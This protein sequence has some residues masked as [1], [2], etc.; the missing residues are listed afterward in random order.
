[1]VGRERELDALAE[2]FASTCE[3]TPC[4][5][6]IGGEAGVGKSR[7]VAEF[8]AGLPGRA[9]VLPGNC[10]ALGA[11]GLDFAP[12][13]AILR[14][15]VRELGAVDVLNLLPR[16]EAGDLGRL[17]PALGPPPAPGDTALARARLF[18]QVLTLL[19]GLA[20]QQP[21]VL[22]VEDAHW[23][24]RSSRDL[25]GF[26]ARSCEAAL[27]T[28]VTYRTDE[29]GPADPLRP[30]LAD[31]ARLKRGR[32]LELGRLARS[33]T[34]RQLRG[35]LGHEPAP[36]D[37][38]RIYR[39][40]GGNPLLVE[41]LLADDEPVPGPIRDLLVAPLEQLP[42]P[43]REVVRAAAVGGSQIRHALLAAVTGLDDAA[44]SRALRPAVAAHLLVAG[45][46]GYVF[47]HALIQEM[48][49]TDL[50]PGERAA[51]HLRYA[52]ALESGPPAALPGRASVE[53]AHH[54]HAAGPAHAVHALTT[55]WQ[56]AGDAR[57]ALAYAEELYM[58]TL[59]LDRWGQVPDAAGFLGTGRPAVMAAAIEAAV[60][61]GETERAMT[62]IETALAEP[63]PDPA[64]GLLLRHRGELRHA[65]GLPGDIDDL[66]EAA[67]LVPAGHAARASVL[68]A[69]AN[70]LLTIPREAA[71][72]AAAEEAMRAASAVGDIRSQVMA[73]VNLGYARARAGD[74]NAQLPGFAAARASA[75]RAGDAATVLHAYRC[76]AD[77]LQGIGSYQ[78]AAE[79]SRRGLAAAARAGLAR[80]AGPTQ[81]G[82][83]AEALICLGHWD[84]ADEILDHAL[85]LTPTPSLRGY[86]LV[87][88][89]SIDLA[90]GVLPRAEA[91][92]RYAHE[93]F[94][95]GTA[96]AQDYLLLVGL[97]V[98]L[99]LAQGRPAKA[100]ALVTEALACS[101]TGASARYLW[102]VLV[103]G[104]R[105]A[106]PG[107]GGL[108]DALR[109]VAA[110]LPVIGPVQ[111]AHRLTFAA[112]NSRA[113]GPR[114]WDHCAAAWAELHQPY[115]Q[116]EALVA[117]AEAAVE[118][119]QGNAAESRLRAAA[120]TADRLGTCPLRERIDR[121]ARLARIAPI[122]GPDGTAAP[123]DPREASRQRWGLTPREYQVLSLIAVGR[124]NREIAEELFISVKT[125]STHVSSI[126]SKLN[127]SSRVQAATVAYRLHVLYVP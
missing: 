62:L 100:A 14:G 74:V 108:P 97:E 1:M 56:A 36:E 41:A 116:T 5:V 6:L 64:R 33:D 120:E 17:L 124:T 82:N 90:R 115:Q 85:E 43:T 38:N 22:V 63:S 112:E 69:L 61:A 25:L 68:N 32:Y 21:I 96:Y 99:R 88:R 98:N 44:L 109:E 46:D 126:L 54:W 31:L 123:E 122:P 67:R 23:A 60:A 45:E 49:E 10:L 104:A 87:L 76:E 15:L 37:V 118:A 79:V 24:D 53:L 2:A 125:A 95:G 72:R 93:V 59:V 107:P 35:L 58:L 11:D 50:L 30:V 84:E 3:G 70:R 94:T 27:L 86:L 26:I 110:G 65:L 75:E 92:T 73:A 80:T 13:I 119:G 47:R 57:G 34:A 127:V 8:T 121:L 77:V 29:L 28:V 78:Q 83:L 9:R 91:A 16:G 52:K 81:A 18:E 66:E 105:A 113:P 4:V 101:D 103:A 55:A 40:S 12:F 102:P 89:G 114:D 51:L 111:H 20:E 39:R 7:L 117:A 42:E 71:G 48:L 106:G 19:E